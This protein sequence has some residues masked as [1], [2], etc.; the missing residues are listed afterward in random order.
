MNCSLILRMEEMSLL[1]I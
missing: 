1:S